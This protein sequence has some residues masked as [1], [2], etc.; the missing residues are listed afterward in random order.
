MQRQ[1]LYARWRVGVIV[2]IL[3]ALCSGSASAENFCGQTIT[4]RNMCA[5]QTEPCV[6][7]ASPMYACITGAFLDELAACCESGNYECSQMFGCV[8]T[9][10]QYVWNCGDCTW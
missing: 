6:L 5:Q 7:D 3:C 9:P 10:I 4:F 1:T 2:G 8:M